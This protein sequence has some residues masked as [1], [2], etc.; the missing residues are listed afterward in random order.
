MQTKIGL[1]TSSIIDKNFML[2]NKTPGPGQYV[3]FSEFSGL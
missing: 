1:D 3:S 2:N